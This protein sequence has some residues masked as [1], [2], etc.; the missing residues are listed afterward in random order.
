MQI[1]LEACVLWD[2]VEGNAPSVPIDKAAL[3]AI[4]RA[5]PAD[6][7]ATLVTKR[8]AKEA[9]DAVK[10]MRVGVDRVKRATAQR[11]RKEFE[12]I[13]FRDGET[14]DS[15]AM[16]ITAL[17]NHLRSLG[18]QVD[19]EKVVEKILREVPERYAQ[20]A[21]SIETLLDLSTLSVEEL[22]GRLRSSEGRGGGSSSTTNNAGVLLLTEEEWEQRR[23]QREHGQGSANGRSKNG[24]GGKKGKGKT[25]NGNGRNGNGERDMSTVKCYNCNHM[26]HFSK[27]CPEPQR[28]RKGRANL[29]QE[30]KEEE[31]LLMAR[32]GEVVL[33]APA[34][35]DTDLILLNEKHSMASVTEEA[36]RCDTSWFLDS[37]ASNHMSGRREYF[38]ELDTSVRGFVKLGDDTTVEIEGRGTIL[39]VC[40]NGEHLTLPE[41]Y[42][43]PKLCSNIVSLGQ[44]DEIGFDTHIR[45]GQL[46]LRDSDGR[47]LARVSRSRGRLYILHL[48]LARPVCLATHGGEDAWRWHA[49]YGHMH[50]DALRRLARGDMVHGLPMLDEVE[51]C[52]DAC[53]A[54]KH[55]RAP[56]PRQAYNRAEK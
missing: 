6:L 43:I 38:S 54:G 41:V 50:F 30:E 51:R 33:V 13:A 17:V 32:I 12:A 42:Y 9:W 34:E 20:M 36:G 44:L 2:A 49:R 26:G 35:R 23:Q 25:K 22:L 56:F 21:C 29:A 27:Q 45:H 31:A 18:D 39:F 1:N 40:K 7:Q 47:L 5:V 14:L 3:A 24:N 8:T 53:L 28:E 19:E 10:M 15:F 11:L 37:G 16:R 52:C 55:K 4:L 46:Q 48:K